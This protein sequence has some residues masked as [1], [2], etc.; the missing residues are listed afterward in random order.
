MNKVKEIVLEKII[1]AMESGNIPWRQQ[2]HQ[3][4]MMPTNWLSKKPYSGINQILL[5]IRA[6][7]L[8][9]ASRYWATYKQI[10]SLGGRLKERSESSLIVY[11]KP[12]DHGEFGEE[13]RPRS[14]LRYYLVFNLSQTTGIEYLT[15]KE[16][17]DCKAARIKSLYQDIP[18][19]A[20]GN[21]SYSR[22]KDIINSPDP[23]DYDSVDFYWANLFHE[24]IHSTGHPSRLDREMGHDNGSYSEEELI[25]EIGSAM[26]CCRAGILQRTLEDSASYIKGWLERLKGDKN[27][28]FKAAAQAQKAVDYILGVKK[29]I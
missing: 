2:W 10:H 18:P 21:P 7:E 9:G 27:V 1:K 5:W 11:Y 24:M 6:S 16:G 28:L 17:F 29:D 13:E 3:D 25:A 19:I 22:S 20:F 23:S 14:V 4:F 12:I 8:E 15:Y 26:L